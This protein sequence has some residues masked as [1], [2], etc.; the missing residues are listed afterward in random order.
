MQRPLSL[1][2]RIYDNFAFKLNIYY[3]T[4]DDWEADNLDPTDESVEGLENPGGYDAI[5]RYGDEVLFDDGG[6]VKSYPG[7]GN[8]YRNGIEEKDVVDYDT[9]NL[10]LAGSVHYKFKEDLELQYG[11]NFGFGT[12]VYQGITGTALRISPF[13]K[14]RSS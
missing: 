6:D 3:L 7:L 1:A 10:K 2:I 5:N 9:R 8:Y 14:I 4:A 13:F 11:V 12:T